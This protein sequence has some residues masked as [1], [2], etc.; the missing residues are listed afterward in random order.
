MIDKITCKILHHIYLIL[1]TFNNYPLESKNAFC[2]GHLTFLGLDPITPEKQA[3]ID[4]ILLVYTPF[5]EGMVSKKLD[6]KKVTTDVERIKKLKPYIIAEIDDLRTK[7]NS[8]THTDRNIN[9]E[10][11]INKPSSFYKNKNQH[12]L[13]LTYKSFKLNMSLNPLFVPLMA[14]V[15]LFV[16]T[17]TDSYSVKDRKKSGVK[18]EET[19]VELMVDPL[20]KVLT[21][22][23]YALGAEYI[24]NPEKVINY[25]PCIDMDVRVKNKELLSPNQ[26]NGIGMQGTIV[27]LIE[28]KQDFGNWIEVDCRKCSV[29]IYLWLASE[30]TNVIPKN[31]QRVCKGDRLI[32]KNSTIGSS[33]QMYLMVAF[34]EDVTI[35]EECKFKITIDKKKPKRKNIISPKVAITVPIVAVSEEVAVTPKPIVEN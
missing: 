12:E 1:L 2:Q 13:L 14:Q 9:K 30:I 8:I 6:K 33:T 18:A 5:D 3:M 29:D 23:F 24:D 10:L 26:F 22:N 35:I 15:N 25:F 16:K 19:S 34:A 4:A 21:S 17:V 31:A 7:I 28:V 32:F 27:N 11:G 20:R